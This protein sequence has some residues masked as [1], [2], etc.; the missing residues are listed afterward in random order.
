MPCR[1]PIPRPSLA[2]VSCA[3]PRARWNWKCALLPLPRR[4]RHTMDTS[5]IW[6]SG[7]AHAIEG[8][9]M[10]SH[11]FA[12]RIT[13]PFD[14]TKSESC[15]VG[16]GQRIVTK[17]DRQPRQCSAEREESLLPSSA[18]R[19]LSPSPVP[20]CGG[21]SNNDCV[22]DVGEGGTGEER[23]DAAAGSAAAAGVARVDDPVPRHQL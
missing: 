4:R 3:L 12:Y 17:W 13:Q 11:R 2:A 10:V 5:R 19:P 1:C 20:E 23:D 18:L 9:S 14:L 16:H 6:A 8:A 22:E 7:K 15:L 21:G